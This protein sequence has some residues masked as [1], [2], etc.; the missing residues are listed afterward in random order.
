MGFRDLGHHSPRFLPCHRWASAARQGGGQCGPGEASLRARGSTSGG[1]GAG[2]KGSAETKMKD[3]QMETLRKQAGVSQAVSFFLQHRDIAVGRPRC[4]VLVLPPAGPERQEASQA[5][6]KVLSW[7]KSSF[8]FFPAYKSSS[9][10]S[11]FN[12]I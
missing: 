3:M 8:A 1:R 7:P 5:S 2:G 4:H 12:F 6:G 9:S 10:A 11:V